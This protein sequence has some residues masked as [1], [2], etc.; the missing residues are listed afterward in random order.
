MSQDLVLRARNG[1]HEAFTALVAASF[2]GLFRLARLILVDGGD[3]RPIPG[4]THFAG[5]W[6]PQWSPDGT[7]ILYRSSGNVSRY[8]LRVVGAAGEDRLVATVL[9]DDWA[10]YEWSPAGD[11]ILVGAFAVEPGV[12]R[13][14]S[15]LDTQAPRD[16]AALVSLWR[17]LA[18]GSAV[19]L[20]AE[21]V[22]GFDV[23]D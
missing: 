18:D 6:G 21:G 1:D 17:V 13:A 7:Q 11:A 19:E 12:G 23:K 4:S 10:G 3:P 20:V 2:D 9:S 16:Q 5:V 15:Q 8:D 14:E 22:N